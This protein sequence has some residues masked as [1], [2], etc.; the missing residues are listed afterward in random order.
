MNGPVLDGT[1]RLT[2][3]GMIAAVGVLALMFGYQAML[4][5]I[6]ASLVEGAGRGALS[7]ASGVA[8]F[9]LARYRNDLL[10]C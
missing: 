6:E 2:V 9:M 5:L 3:V 7:L 8:T 1:M 10:D 4:L